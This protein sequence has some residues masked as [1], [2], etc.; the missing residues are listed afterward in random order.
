MG[1][2]RRVYLKG[3]TVSSPVIYES[4]PGET[5]IFDGSSLSTDDT[6]EEQW[7][8]GRLQLR[9]EYAILRKVEVRNMP[10]YGVRIFGNHNMVEGCRLHDNH[11]SGLGIANLVDGYSAKDTGGSYNVVRDNIIYD[12]SD[13]GLT[14]HNYGDGDN[15]D[16]ITI[17]SGVSNLISH[18]TVYGNS[19]DGIDTWK[20]MDSTVEYNLVY[21]HGKGPRGNGNGIKLGGASAESP[22]GANARARHNISHSNKRIGINV[23]SGKNVLIEYNTVFGNGDF[24]Y[25]LMKD[26][27]L[28]GNISLQN[29][30]GH[31]GWSKGKT[32]SDSSWQKGGSLKVLSTDPASGDFLRPSPS[33][34]FESMGAYA[35][36][37]R[38]VVSRVRFVADQELRDGFV[39]RTFQGTTGVQMP[40]RLFV[41][42]DRVRSGPLPAIIFLHGGSGAGTDNVRQISGHNTPGTHVWTTPVMQAR[43]PA[44]V[45]APQ[46]LGK[47]QWS[48]PDSDALAPYAALVVELLE[49]LS[50]EFAID[51]QR[52][53]LV[54]QSRGGR[55]TWDLIAKRPDLFAAAVP[56]C[57]DGN[58]ARVVNARRVPVWAFHGAKD[59]IVPVTGS[60]DMVAGLRAVGSPVEYTEYPEAGHGV[61]RLVFAEPKLHRWLFAQARDP[62]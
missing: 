33:G 21:G 12:N 59:T 16:G 47:N 46:L 45:I 5:A 1:G 4:Y 35:V 38:G 54:G 10:T 60:R 48:A 49:S 57:G 6:S 23:N 8:E 24:G 34:G 28:V 52:V 3:G 25:A 55:G 50:R 58:A 2:A 40:F 26:T 7:R 39:A 11:L 15:A 9:G 22:L 36:R 37:G 41:P 13:I 42:H 61:W 17:H 31:V 30:S 62:R 53:Y 51:P 56:L 18:N 14:H 27:V 43:N 32:Q 29:K 20:S 19:D 44:F